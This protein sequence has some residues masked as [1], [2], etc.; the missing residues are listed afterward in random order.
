MPSPIGNMLCASMELLQLEVGPRE[1]FRFASSQDIIGWDN[2]L[3]GM[4]S[5]HL[6]PIQIQYSHLLASAS[7]LNV[8]DWMSPRLQI[9][10]EFRSV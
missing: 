5:V 2:F 4:V 9:P 8:D 6:R 7:M 1:F 3:L 10:A